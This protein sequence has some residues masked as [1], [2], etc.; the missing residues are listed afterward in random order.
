MLMIA[1]V[2]FAECV[3]HRTATLEAVVVANNSALHTILICSSYAIFTVLLKLLLYLKWHSLYFHS[4]KIV[5]NK[6][7]QLS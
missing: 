5:C 4:G 6:Q 2:S 1:F 7:S 3:L